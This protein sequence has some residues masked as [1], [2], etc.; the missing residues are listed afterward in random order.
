MVGIAGEV[1]CRAEQY[2]VAA[3]AFESISVRLAP[4]TGP[5]TRNRAN[6]ITDRVQHRLRRIN[7]HG[8]AAFLEHHESRSRNQLVD[9]LGK[10]DRADPVMPSGD[11][12]RRR[13]DARQFRP[14]IEPAQET[15]RAK[16]RFNG[17]GAWIARP[18]VA[19]AAAGSWQRAYSGPMIS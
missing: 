18:R 1:A 11:D 4:G 15:I 8:M 6:K 17:S 2:H 3:L 14:Q 13:R 19:A 16:A 9:F 12:Q 5:A 7:S 10:R